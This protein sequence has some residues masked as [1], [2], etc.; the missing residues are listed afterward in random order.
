M[1]ASLDIPVHITPHP[2]EIPNPIPFEQDTVH[3][4]YDPEYANRCFLALAH[5]DRVFRA[6]GYDY[7]GKKGVRDWWLPA[8]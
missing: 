6:F 8:H 7:L 4:S 3:T 1:L 2:N 5:S